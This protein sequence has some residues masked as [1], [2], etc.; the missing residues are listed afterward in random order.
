MAT[1]PL[2]FQQELARDRVVS[3][4]RSRGERLRQCW[5]P[6]LKPSPQYPEEHGLLETL[7]PGRKWRLK[8][9]PPW[10]DSPLPYCLSLGVEP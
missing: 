3:V 1:E 6:A 10:L 7:D 4:P 8:E 2:R 5:V 9:L